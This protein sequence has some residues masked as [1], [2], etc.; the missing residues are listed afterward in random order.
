MLKTVKKIELKS[1]LANSIRRFSQIQSD[2]EG[3]TSSS[4]DYGSTSD[5][6]N[7][8]VKNIIDPYKN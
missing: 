5:G 3:T 6:E 4:T 8:K 7:K 1:I 2:S